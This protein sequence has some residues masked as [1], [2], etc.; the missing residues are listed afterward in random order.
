MNK[1]PREIQRNLNEQISYIAYHGCRKIKCKNCY[2]NKT[3]CD[4]VPA[5]SQI[6]AMAIIEKIKENAG[7]K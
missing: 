3:V 6:L 2:L 5:K 7:V 1:T 4:N